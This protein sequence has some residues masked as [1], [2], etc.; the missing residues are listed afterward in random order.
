VGDATAMHHGCSV[1]QDREAH[2]KT[3]EA[4]LAEAALVNAQLA[5]ARAVLQSGSR[6]ESATIKALS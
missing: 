2:N 3:V 6:R 1:R 5:M 4:T